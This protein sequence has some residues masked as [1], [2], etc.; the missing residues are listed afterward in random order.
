MLVRQNVFLRDGIRVLADSQRK[1]APGVV[2]FFGE[3][4]ISLQ[5]KLGINRE[6]ALSGSHDGVHNCARGSKTILRR[7]GGLGQRIGE[8]TLQRNLAERPARFGS[9]ENR[10]KRLRGLREILAGLLHLAHLLT[11]LD[12]RVGRGF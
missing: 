5:W 10:L 9:A 11:H 2:A 6:Q 7:I 8:Q 4:P 3:A 12:E 1:I